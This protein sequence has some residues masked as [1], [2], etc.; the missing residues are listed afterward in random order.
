MSHNRENVTFQTADGKWG[1]GFWEF[2]NTKPYTDETF[3]SEWDVEY[4][5]DAFWFASLNHNTPEEAYTA[6]TRTHGNPAG[7]VILNYADNQKACD[8]YEMYAKQLI[9]AQ[10]FVNTL[11][12]PYPIW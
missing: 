11:K 1:I 3:D 7:T 6:Y 8:T 2:Y 12:Q 5:Y 9:N 4:Y 10:R